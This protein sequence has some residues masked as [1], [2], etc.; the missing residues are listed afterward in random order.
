[1]MHLAVC[2]AV[3]LGLSACGGDD[4]GGDGGTDAGHIAYCGNDVMDDNEACDDGNNVSGDGCSSDCASDESCGND[5][6]DLGE[7]CDDGNTASG[8]DCNE[9]CTSDETCG[10]HITDVGEE[11]DDG[12]ELSG[13]GCDS[14]AAECV[15]GRNYDTLQEAVDDDSCPVIHVAGGTHVG[16]TTIDRTVEIRGLPDQ[17][18]VLDGDQNGSVITVSAGEVTLVDVN[19]RNGSADRGGGVH[20]SGGSLTMTRVV[21]RQNTSVIEGGGLYSDADLTCQQCQ[22]T[23]NQNLGSQATFT[24]RGG[25]VSIGINGTALLQGS[26]ISGNVGYSAY[27]N[28]E[29]SV[30]FGGG[31]YNAGNT[32]LRDTRVTGNIAFALQDAFT[33][34]DIRAQGGGIYND[35]ILAVVK[36]LIDHNVASSSDWTDG[37]GVFANAGSTG[38]T[39]STIY[40]N[41]STNG[42]TGGISLVGGATLV[43]RS[44]TIMNNVGNGFGMFGGTVN[45]RNSIVVGNSGN[46]CDAPVGTVNT[47]YNIWGSTN[48][49][50]AG[51]ADL[52]VMV[53][54]CPLH[55]WGGPTLSVALDALDTSAIDGADPAGCTDHTGAALTTDQRGEARVVGSGCDVGA[56]EVQATPVCNGQGVLAGGTGVN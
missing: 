11:C 46:D 22:I 10:N 34:D 16:T 35:G 44:A 36:C 21:L 43:V 8:D 13:D 42:R 15:V 9:T 45:I 28:S 41:D 1:M 32:T 33:Q 31:I 49:T 39:A 56:F 30:S 5:V 23:D 17:V 52:D 50:F 29:D 55:D 2:A 53:R 14:C 7:V 18:A 48:C 24:A 3:V 37:A 19:L 20:H 38:I 51:D 25:G 47:G 54:V 6:V 4:D 12:N 40:G 26:A 27:D